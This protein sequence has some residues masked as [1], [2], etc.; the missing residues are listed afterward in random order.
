MPILFISLTP[1]TR[2]LKPFIHQSTI[3]N[4]LNP[5]SAIRNPQSH[6][7]SSACGLQCTPPIPDLSF[8]FNVCCE[9]VVPLATSFMKGI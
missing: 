7:P 6:T 8:G 4:L 1:D 9:N 3:Y 5:Q 2:H